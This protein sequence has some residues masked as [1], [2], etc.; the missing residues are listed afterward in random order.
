MPKYRVIDQLH[1]SAAGPDTMAK[2]TVFA[3]SKAAGDELV[4]AG[5][6]EFVGDDDEDAASEAPAEKAEAAPENKAIIAAPANK[7]AK[8]SS[9]KT[10]G[11]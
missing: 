6:V 7:A 2:G 9:R 10:K 1:V 3:A 11:K 5:H 4:K 8:T